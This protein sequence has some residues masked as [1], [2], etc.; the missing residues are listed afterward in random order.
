[1]TVVLEEPAAL[2]GRMGDRSSSETSTDFYQVIQYIWLRTSEKRVLQR[3]FVPKTD[4]VTGEWRKLHN[5]ELNDLCCSLNIIRVIK[6]RIT[7]WAGH[8]EH[9]GR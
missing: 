6:S 1:M 3:I 7:R 9:M 4:D 8:V 5:E 2:T